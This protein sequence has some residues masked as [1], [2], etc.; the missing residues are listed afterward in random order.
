MI[1]V[2]S[3]QDLAAMKGAKPPE[4]A[5][6]QGPDPLLTLADAVAQSSRTQDERTTAIINALQELARALDRPV[7]V[8]APV[9]M[10]ARPTL[11]RFK[12]NRNSSTGFLDEI[13]AKAE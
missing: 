8:S 10:P 6:P 1:K 13:V 4:P 12:F 11:W 3:T 2:K 7:T 5:K 9:N